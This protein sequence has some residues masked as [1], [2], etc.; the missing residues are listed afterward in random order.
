MVG[1]EKIIRTN[2]PTKNILIKFIIENTGETLRPNP[3]DKY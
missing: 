3:S 2:N 1:I